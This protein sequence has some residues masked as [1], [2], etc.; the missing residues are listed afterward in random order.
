[1]RRI[2]SVA[3][4][5]LLLAIAPVALA[6]RGGHTGHAGGFHGS[7]SASRSFSSFSG[8]APRNFSSVPRNFSSVPRYSMAPA[9]RSR[10]AQTFSVQRRNW[11]RRDWR[12]RGQYRPAYNGY[13]G[14]YSYPGYFVNSWEL[15]PG[16][17]NDDSGD[18]DDAGSQP[19]TD[20]QQPE[21]QPEPQ[22]GYAPPP[23]DGYRADYGDY[24]PPPPYQPPAAGSQAPVSPEPQLT[25]VF[26]DGHTQ[27]IRNYV[28][29]SD[30]LI[31]M[32][33]AASGRELH[34]PLA[35]LNLPATEQDAQQAG[36]D[37]TPPV[38]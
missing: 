2:S 6:Q 24:A 9:A 27:Q 20:A 36:L 10:Y 30:T 11:N 33:E 13:Y 34:I 4:L 15:L 1:M 28:L 17:L 26:K 31:D 29:T 38:S 7:F 21:T 3:L 25:L 19:E 14:G 8:F 37:F 5:S 16:D 18:Y 32:D 12:G 22:S 23:G 35:T